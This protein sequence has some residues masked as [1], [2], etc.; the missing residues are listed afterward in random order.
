MGATDV[1]QSVRH[2]KMDFDAKLPV[3]AA[4]PK[5]GKTVRWPKFQLHGG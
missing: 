2:P 5:M 4:V 3:T 1:F